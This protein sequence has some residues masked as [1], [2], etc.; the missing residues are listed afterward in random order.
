M[1]GLLTHAPLSAAEQRAHDNHRPLVVVAVLAVLAVYTYLFTHIAEPLGIPYPQ[2]LVAGLGGQIDH[3]FDS[4]RN[5]DSNIQVLMTQRYRSN[6]DERLVLLAAIAVAFLS[7]YFLPLRYKQPALVFWTVV[8][9][10][11]LYGPRATSGLLC[12][13]LLV[14][15]VFHPGHRYRFL[16]S[17]LVGVAVYSGFLHDFEDRT[18]YLIPAVGAPLLAVLLYRYAV[19][20]LLQDPRAAAVLRS[21]IIHSA[22]LAIGTSLVVEALRGDG[23]SVP[24]G[25]LLFFWQWARLVM[26]HIDYKDGLVP[27]A[28][29]LGQYLPVF[30]NPGVLPNWNW[31]VTIPQGYAYIQNNF[32]CEDKNRLVMAGVKLL[33][34]ALVYL[35]FWNWIRYFLVDVFSALGIEVYNSRTRTMVHEFVRG[36]EVT[37]PSVLATTLLDL[38]RFMMFF[39]GVV[40]FKVGIWRICGYRIDPYYNKPWLATDLMTFWTRFAYHY[41]EFLVRA[42]YYPAFFRYVRLNRN[43]RIF[44]ASMAAAGLGNLI[45]HITERTFFNDLEWDEVSYML[46]TW[47]Y[48]FFLGLGIAVSQIYL[49]RRK[50]RRKPWSRD[51]WLIK[52]V[53]AVYLVLQYFAIIHIFIRPV[54]DSSVGDLF[55]LFL[56]GFGIHL[57]E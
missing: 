25:L 28:A 14:Y 46:G 12:A 44:I 53:V 6:D 47:P 5:V 34:I 26:Y 8:A 49:M 55:Q 20:P 35:V 22:L 21:L 23:W 54:P 16:L 13:H 9:I 42:F 11:L 37:T 18:V 56:I 51:W 52:D 41:R 36:A 57:P 4:D 10:L 29:G 43:L 38:I 24:L 1:P 30:F 50:R 19:L 7:A 27:E 31:G 15:T 40:H 33:C 45:W 17:A 32:L 2:E 48:F 39:A 3:V